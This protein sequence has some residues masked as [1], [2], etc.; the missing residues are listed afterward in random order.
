[1]KLDTVSVADANVRCWSA[2]SGPAVVYLHGF[3]GTV[4]EAPFLARLAESH[5]VY[6]P[7]TPGYGESTGFEKMDDIIDLALFYRK[8]VAGLG[9]GSVDVIGHSLG[10]MFAAEFAALSPHLVRK[11]VLVSPFGLWLDDHQ[12]PDI[13]GLAGDRLKQAAWH[14]PAR[15]PEPPSTNGASPIDKAIRH[16]FDQAVAAKFLWPI[17]DRGLDGRLPYVEAPTLIVT[18][19]SDSIIPSVYGEAFASRIP[20]ARAVTIDEA[21]HYPQI[22]QEERFL[23]EVNSFLGK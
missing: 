11:L 6:A 14:D 19:A 13:F 2:G 4:S 10:G 17:P 1:M 8:L 23:A 9:Q 5:T 18:G 22:E 3:E 7:E 20:D 15:V 21:G 12:I 16:T